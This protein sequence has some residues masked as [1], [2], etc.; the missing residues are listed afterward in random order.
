MSQY[1]IRKPQML[2][3]GASLVWRSTV[4]W[5]VLPLSH[6]LSLGVVD[7]TPEALLCHEVHLGTDTK[8]GCGSS[9]I[10][11]TPHLW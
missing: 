11:R 9:M 1:D 2:T 5:S 8:Q 10:G 6:C 3:N 4:Y 7:T